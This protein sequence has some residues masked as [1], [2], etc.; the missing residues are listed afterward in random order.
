[1]F[2]VLCLAYTALFLVLRPRVMS[3]PI[4]FY[5]FSALYLIFLAMT[6]SI[7]F[8]L[9]FSAIIVF[10]VVFA[11]VRFRR[12]TVMRWLSGRTVILVS[13]VFVAIGIVFS[14]SVE[15]TESEIDYS[16]VTNYPQF[17]MQKLFAD[18]GVIWAGALDTILYSVGLFP[19]KVNILLQYETLAGELF[20]VDFG[21]HNII[22]EVILRLGWVVGFGLILFL[23]RLLIL[24]IRALFSGRTDLHFL[25]ATALAMSLLLGGGLLGQYIMMPNFAYLMFTLAGLCLAYAEYTPRDD[26]NVDIHPNQPSNDP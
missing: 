24:L 3:M 12:E 4:H 21:A 10:L 19:Q 26:S 9:I 23:G 14:D 6:A 15:L 20:E 2:S 7:K 8:N 16:D 5:G 18:R 25:F 22:F 1:M 11:L 17:M 13:L